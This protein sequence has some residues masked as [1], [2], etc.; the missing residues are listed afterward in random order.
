MCKKKIMLIKKFIAEVRKIY[1]YLIMGYDYCSETEEYNIWH[2][3]AE[4]EFEDRNFTEFV[5]KLMKEIL[6]ENNIFDFSFGYDHLKA[7]EFLICYKNHV[8]NNKEIETSFV[9]NLVESMG[10]YYQNIELVKLDELKTKFVFG[11]NNNLSDLNIFNDKN[12]SANGFEQC[13]IYGDNPTE[14]IVA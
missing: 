14:R 1:P 5:G 7:K 2:I 9:S 11:Q 6:L 13:L 3:N 10:V 8:D 4:L 12:N